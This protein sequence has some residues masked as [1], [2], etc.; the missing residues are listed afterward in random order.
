MERGFFKEFLDQLERHKDTLK[1]FVVSDASGDRVFTMM[2]FG[3]AIY[4]YSGINNW[5]TPTDLRLAVILSGNVVYA[6]DTIDFPAGCID[7]IKEHTVSLRNAYEKRLA[8]IDDF[9]QQMFEQL[10]APKQEFDA[11]TSALNKRM[12]RKRILY[13]CAFEKAPDH[14]LATYPP[15]LSELGFPRHVITLDT[16]KAELSGFVDLNQ[17]ARDFFEQ[18]KGQYLFCKARL[19]AIEGMVQ[20]MSVVDDWEVAFAKSLAPV[21]CRHTKN[22]TATLLIADK[23]VSAKMDA[24][25]I[26]FRLVNKEPIW[27]EDFQQVLSI[28]ESVLLLE[29]VNHRK[30][31]CSDIE[32]IK[33][34]NKTVY[35]K[36]T[37]DMLTE[38][39]E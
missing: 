39:Q 23:K 11:V 18:K 8:E 36:I 2:S 12:A 30:V 7:D 15:N 5:K 24:A 9:I 33:H 10:N 13:E 28:K 22:I 14:T 34:R 31:F 17:T 21:F 19:D 37:D 3:K 1:P 38:E 6:V 4:V 25:K 32:C 16:Y 26:L 27:I 20:S 29:Y 35:V